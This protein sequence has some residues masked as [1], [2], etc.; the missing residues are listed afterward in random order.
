M[1]P[2]L[3]ATSTW[4]DSHQYLA[5]WLEGIALLAIFIWD[6][7]DASAQHKQTLTQMKIMES[8]ARGTE[9]AA[10]AAT[11]SADALINSERAW[12][13][14]GLRPYATQFG[15][16]RW[17]RKDGAPLTTEE[18]T[19]GKH[20]RYWLTITNMGR[21]PAQILGVALNYTCLGKGV[22]DL[23][24]SG[25]GESA[26]KSYRP[27]EHLLGGDGQAVEIGEAIDVGWYIGDDFDAIKKL[28]KTAVI[29]GWIKYRHMFS[30][31]DD[32]YSDF[33]YVYTV[34]EE[35]LTTVG[36]HTRQRQQKAEPPGHTP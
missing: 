15:D 21:G 31:T 24:E 5:L 11:K 25:V 8:Q 13:V 32:C 19:A 27:F 34:S 12:V 23:P 22:T 14:A 18:V 17:Y 2:V 9:I 33:C 10:N 35:K 26:L 20:L 28:E 6:R 36:R 1:C 3:S 16:R 7:I 30:T 29:H 4:L